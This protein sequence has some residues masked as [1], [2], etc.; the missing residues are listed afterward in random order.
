MIIYQ[1]P[2]EIDGKPIVV[3]APIAKSRNSKTG[4]ML[5]TYILRA[6]V[7]PRDAN[8][9]G[10]DYSICGNC[11]HRGTPT[12][13]PDRK[14][15]IKRSCYVNIAQGV[16]IV[17]KQF[18]AGKYQTATDI[19]AVGRDRMV[20]LGTYGDPA[21]VPSY[22]WDELLSDCK[23]HTAYSHQSGMTGA[24]FRPDLFMTSADSLKEAEQAWADN[25]R[26]FRV[27]S[28]V[29]DVSPLEILCPASE[30]AGRRTQ[31]QTCGLCAGSAIKAKSI[32]IVAHGAGRNNFTG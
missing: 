18:A 3:I 11:P 8:K 27:V 2:S 22:V 31:C 25:R 5:Q 26:T 23:G 29:T 19:A 4:A 15:A 6:D 24:D 20:R 28:D 12:D 9:S 32:A 1:G 13:D 17:Y 21:A 10:Q 16:L 7:D 30:E 14:L